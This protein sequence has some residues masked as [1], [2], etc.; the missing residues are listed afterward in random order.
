MG[1]MANLQVTDSNG[2]LITYQPRIYLNLAE[3][4]SI[5]RVASKEGKH[6]M[7]IDGN[8]VK[9]RYVFDDESYQW[10]EQRVIV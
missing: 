2:Y 5:W 1:V 7:A 3:L 4:N 6:T 10:A 9:L 8:N